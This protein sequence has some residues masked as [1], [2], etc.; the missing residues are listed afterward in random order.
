MFLTAAKIESEA[1]TSGLQKQGQEL[2]DAMKAQAAYN[3]IMRETKLAHGDFRDT[4]DSLPNLLR[5]L[6]AT[7][8]DVRGAVEDMWRQYELIRGRPGQRRAC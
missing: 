4:A 7:T 6:R 1:M 5:T 2:T 8:E 3:I